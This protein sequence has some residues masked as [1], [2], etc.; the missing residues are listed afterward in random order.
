MDFFGVSDGFESRRQGEQDDGGKGKAENECSSSWLIWSK[1][2]Q[3]G[4]KEAKEVVKRKE[5]EQKCW[6]KAAA[7]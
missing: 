1:K 7:G 4:K 5:S 2:S 3:E 6:T